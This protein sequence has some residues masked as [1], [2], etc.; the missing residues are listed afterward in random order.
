MKVAR[1]RIQ[2]IHALVTKFSFS[3]LFLLVLIFLFTFTQKCFAVDR[4]TA[5]ANSLR[6]SAARTYTLYL[7]SAGNVKGFGYLDNEQARYA[8]LETM[9]GSF[10]GVKA[11]FAGDS[12]FA[13]LTG[14]NKAYF[15]GN[16]SEFGL[17]SYLDNVKKIAFGKDHVVVLYTNG[18]IE[19]FLRSPDYYKLKTIPSNIQGIISDI[20]SGYHHIIAL[21]NAGNLYAWGNNDYDQ[22]SI[23]LSARSGVA[24]IAAGSYH[25]V[26]LKQDG[27]VICFGANFSQQSTITT[28]TAQNLINV[29]NVQ[30]GHSHS[31]ALRSDGKVVVWGDETVNP[32]KP[33]Q[34]IYG[35]NRNIPQA[36]QGKVVGITCGTFHTVALLNDGSVVGWGLNDF[37]QAFGPI[38]IKPSTLERTVEPTSTIEIE[39]PCSVGSSQSSLMLVDSDGGSISAQITS[40][41]KKLKL[42]LSSPLKYE[43]FYYLK[44]S[45]FIYSTISQLKLPQLNFTFSTWRLFIV[46][47]VRSTAA[48][49][50]YETAVLPCIVFFEEALDTTYTMK[51]YSEPYPWK[52]GETINEKGIYQL[53]VS[54]KNA[55]NELVTKIINFYV[56]PLKRIFGSSRIETAV[57]LSQEIF[58]SA[59]TVILAY[60]YD[61]PDALSA[62]P[63]AAHFNCPIL[64]TPKD[65]LPKTVSDEITRLN[66]RTVYIIGG[67]GV[68]SDTIKENLQKKGLTVYRL[69]GKDRYATSAEVAK[70]LIQLKGEGF[71]REAYIATGENYPDAL[72]AGGVAGKRGV[73]IL[74]TKKDSLPQAVA[75]VITS[76]SI[77]KTY[78]VGGEGVVS[79]SV[80][81]L[82]PAPTRIFGQTRY[83][84]AIEIAK[85]ALM[86]GFTVKNI[87]ITTGENYPDALA[88]AAA[89]GKT[90]NPVILVKKDTPIPAAVSE[91]IT[92]NKTQVEKITILGGPAVVSDAV[93][94]GLKTL[95]F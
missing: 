31:V 16:F 33:S 10:T 85:H 81:R 17:P 91:F 67:T 9:T 43:K 62:A 48:I 6:F 12:V 71:I 94:N 89:S 79:A 24:Q 28:T 72:A 42:L 87:Y 30:A 75:N 13:I 40:S 82:L 52:N 51:R 55:L 41:G 95:S 15:F 3:F 60:A 22:C 88:C 92:E 83:E 20:A 36:I 5:I 90:A 37:A 53:V 8:F 44:L 69:A 39:F 14:E 73:P 35:P 47:G 2:S 78:V 19:V 45:D 58:G 61:F 74:L 27:K 64:L 84:T 11:V 66:A 86:H 68:I 63:L 26:V 56:L 7:D 50:A 46:N 1:S 32:H 25:N 70:K 77:R 80:Y 76:Y 34:V 4:E 93:K 23:P 21:T 38:L 29:V 65:S 59:N 54:A 49:G 18:T 57:Q